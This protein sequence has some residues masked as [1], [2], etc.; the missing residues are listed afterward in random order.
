MRRKCDARDF[1]LF[2]GII[3]HLWQRRNEF[4]H[5]GSFSHPSSVLEQA[6]EGL[7]AYE[8]AQGA[9]VGSGF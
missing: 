8:R 7:V 2:V 3:R 1:K 9:E 4:V 5:E 6:I